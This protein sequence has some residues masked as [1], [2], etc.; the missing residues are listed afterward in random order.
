METVRFGSEG[1]DVE[2]LQLALSRAGYNPGG[3]DGVFGTRT[4]DALLLFQ[5]DYGLSQDAVAGRQT[6]TRLR[7]F[8]TGYVIRKV[9]RGDT[10]WTLAE[11]YNTTVLRISTANPRVSPTALQVGQ[12]LII[13]L[14]FELAPT[15][16]RYTSTL[17]AL[18]VEGLRVRF[19]FLETGTIG[20]SVA[21]KPIP[22]FAIGEG[23]TQLMYNASHHANEW[24]TTPLLMKFLEEY[25]NAYTTRGAIFST[26]ASALYDQTR[27]YIVPMVNPDG[28]DL[29]N[30]AFAPGSAYYEHATNLARN[31]PSIPFP[32]GWK[33]NIVGVDLNLNY[34]AEW[35]RAREIK[36][37]Q[38]F[39]TPGPRDFV[40]AGPLSQPESEAMHRFTRTHDFALT[41]SYHTQGAVIYWKFLD[42]L[43]QDSYEIG[44][45]FSEVSGYPLEDT[46]EY[47][48]YAGYKDWFI[49]TYN[50]PGYTI[51]AGRGISPLPLTQFDEI[52]ADNLGILVLGM[53]LI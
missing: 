30:G 23:P 28:V 51:E 32:S 42:Y 52:Y 46:P 29:V 48:A 40:G 15:N 45:R 38:G 24:I 13:P 16:V 22:Y 43:P 12:N 36:F 4:R 49:Q 34:P 1:P 14:G 37:S 31:Y 2:L 7:P 35:E 47:S 20:Y 39:T 41:L 18:L 26:D 8:L 50:R 33:A 53:A 25:A 21:R 44:L 5:R 19:P 10:Y 9:R 17:M 27:L 6:W 3:I 11:L